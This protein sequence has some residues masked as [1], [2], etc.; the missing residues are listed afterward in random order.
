MGVGVS[1]GV[2]VAVADAVGDGVGVG[3][4]IGPLAPLSGVDVGDGV[5]VGVAVGV[6][7]SVGV[8]VVVRVGVAVGCASGAIVAVAVG[9][10]VGVCP[11]SLGQD[12]CFVAPARSEGLSL[13][14]SI[15]LSPALQGWLHMGQL[16]VRTPPE[17]AV[18][19]SSKSSRRAIE[20]SSTMKSM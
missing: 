11:E 14:R 1:V 8:G 4:S 12:V 10:G 9:E 2:S 13:I 17:S 18:V 19:A 7:V 6:A 20:P 5:D 16:K 3:V 15:S